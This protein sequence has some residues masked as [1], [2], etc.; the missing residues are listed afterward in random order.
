MACACTTFCGAAE[1]RFT[2]EKADKE[3]RRYREKGPI[4]TTRRL[5][6][7]LIRSG[8]VDRADILDLGAGV[9]ALTFELLDRGVTHAIV[10]EASSAYLEAAAA[11][12]AR[13]GKSPSI[14]FVHADFVAGGQELPTAA[15]VTLDRVICCYPAYEPFL[16][17]ALRHAERGFAMSYPRDRWYVRAAMGFENAKRSRTC[18][19]RTFVHPP[20]RMER[21]IRRA[22]FDLLSRTHTWMWAIDVFVRPSSPR[23]TGV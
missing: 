10:V 13:R 4:A 19:F 9:G 18:S 14:N 17:E 21:I 12:A 6:D 8:L 7:G 22:G 23:Q 5:L 1:E 15:I 2:R 11:E 20:A 3:L 16:E